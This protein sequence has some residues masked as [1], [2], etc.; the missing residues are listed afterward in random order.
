MKRAALFVL[1][2]LATLAPAA[3][4]PEEYS[5]NVHATSSYLLPSGQG[6][7]VVIHSKKYQLSGIPRGGLLALGDYKAK[8]IKDDHQTAYEADQEYEFLFPDNKTRKFE[9]VGQSE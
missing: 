2:L 6:L 8:L 1:L 3:P 7:D 5:I 4:A 9:V